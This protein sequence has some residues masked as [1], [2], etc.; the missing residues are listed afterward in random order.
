[1]IEDEE[2][3]ENEQEE[4]EQNDVNQGPN[5]EQAKDEVKE[6]IKRDSNSSN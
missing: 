2:I 4:E 1:M 6:L 3:N 5:P